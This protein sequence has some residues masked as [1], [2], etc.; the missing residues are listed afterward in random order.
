MGVG[1]GTGTG[2]GTGTG[3]GAGN[4]PDARVESFDVATKL[5]N[6]GPQF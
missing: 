5:P 3:A 6:P 1:L 4:G 2:I